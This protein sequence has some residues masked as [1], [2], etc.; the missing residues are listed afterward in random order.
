M[1][2]VS[3]TAE[4]RQLMLLEK[5]FLASLYLSQNS[6]VAKKIVVNGSDDQLDT[7]IHVLHHIC[8]GKIPVLRKSMLRTQK[9]L[10]FMQI[11][12]GTDDNVYNLQCSS[13]GDKTK[14]I[15]KISNFFPD[16]FFFLFNDKSNE[17]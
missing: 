12:F 13:R 15:S 10:K 5:H 2:E 6:A 7:L 14:K 11:T 4:L 17:K 9:G 1:L 16:L 8:T 3:N